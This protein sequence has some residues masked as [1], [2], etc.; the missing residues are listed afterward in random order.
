MGPGCPFYLHWVVSLCALSVTS[1]LAFVSDLHRPS[2]HSFAFVATLSGG[3]CSP[4]WLFDLVQEGMGHFDLV[5]EEIQIVGDSD[6]YVC[7]TRP[8]AFKGSVDDRNSA[9]FSAVAVQRTWSY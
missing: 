8:E 6:S 5:E 7:C 3:S 9:A 1:F 2:L 4:V